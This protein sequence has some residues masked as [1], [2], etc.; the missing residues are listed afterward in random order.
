MRKLNPSSLRIDGRVNRDSV[1]RDLDLFKR[2]GLINGPGDLGKVIDE[3]FV[4]A[5]LKD[6]GPASK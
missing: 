1:Q 6:I 4:D 2:L 3:S 5:A